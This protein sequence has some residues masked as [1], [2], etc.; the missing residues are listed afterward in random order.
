MRGTQSVYLFNTYLF[1]YL[2]RILSFNISNVWDVQN[3]P[4]HL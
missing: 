1:I 2:S 4:P 3:T